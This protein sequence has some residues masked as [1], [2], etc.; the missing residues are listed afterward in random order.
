[1]ISEN[2]IEK[3]VKKIRTA[4]EDAKTARES[5]EFFRRFPVGQCG[6]TSDVLAQYFID[7]GI[8]PIT[9]VNGTYYGDDWEDIWSH[10]WLLI[11]GLVVDITGDQFK[12]HEKPL[13]NN[14]HVY[15]GPMTEWYYLFEVARSGIHEHNGLEKSWTGYYELK[16]CYE[17]MRKYM[18][19]Q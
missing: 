17:T 14:I 5:G 12:F 15:I 7:N 16:R 11:D 19:S 8:G 18:D 2:E 13:Q 9:Y 10:T 3:I 4:I 6:H 1:M